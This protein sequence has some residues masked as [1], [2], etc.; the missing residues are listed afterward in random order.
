MLIFCDKSKYHPRIPLYISSMLFICCFMLIQNKS[1]YSW[2]SCLFFDEDISCIISPSY[3]ND[4]HDCSFTMSVFDWQR[5]VYE[6]NMTIF[7]EYISLIFIIYLTGLLDLTKLKI[8]LIFWWESI[9]PLHGFSICH[10]LSKLFVCLCVG[11]VG[12][13]GG[14][15]L[16]FWLNVYHNTKHNT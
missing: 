13:G 9:M 2:F 7:F 16:E 10:N 15:C 4:A 14:R 1:L 12:V 8:C 11:H 3:A 5:S 6:I